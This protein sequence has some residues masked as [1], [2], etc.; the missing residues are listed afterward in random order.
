MG[1]PTYYN[2]GKKVCK[3]MTVHDIERYIARGRR[4]HLVGIG[5]VSM[6]PL[7]EVLHGMGMAITGSD[8]RESGTVEH[9]RAL[10]IPVA[11]GHRRE[12]VEGAELVIRTAA[13]HDAN[14]EI[15]AAREAGIPVFERAQ[16]WG[17]IMRSYK[18]ALCIAGTHGKTTTTSMCTH[19]IMAAGLDPTVMI[20]GT[21]PL[22]GAGH[23]VGKGDTIILESCEYCNSFLSFS[24]TVA[25][26]LNIEADHLDFFKDLEDVERSFRAF[27]DLVPPD[28]R[29][30]ANGEDENTMRTLA[31][32]ERP[33]TT[34]G[35]ER[36]DIH[37]AALQ[38]EKG[39]PT[40][41]V[42]VRGE[43]YAHVALG[44]PGL[45]NVKNALA[46][47]AA[48]HALGV[49]GEA[50]ERGLAQFR[51]AGRRFEHKG[52][53]HGAEIYDDYAH[54][55]GELQALLTT[56]KGLGYRRVIC[57]FQPH[58]YSR[59]AALFDDFVRVL[60]EPDV[61]ILAEIFAARETNDIGISSRDL[62]ER[63]PGSR[64]CA[65]LNEVEEVLRDL[66]RP[67]DL[68]LTVGAGDIYTVGE[69]LVSEA[70]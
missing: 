25:V 35:L 30:I 20:G 46:A 36:G 65:D 49:P 57:A 13:V 43:K 51:G 23:R 52:S 50:V 39:L 62:A 15:A 56:A 58:T 70:R 1:G 37:A 40:F 5:G 9:L 10:G 59:T 38:W 47:A 26:I 22:L 8:M 60:R 6:A 53:F 55:P 34:F 66:A 33:V 41:D 27:A 29:I 17:A 28:G 64:Y 11:I 63:I 44:V 32:E 61:T 19:I 48:A 16:A 2:M 24:P 12:N 3:P 21:L 68:I 31:G 69:A 42:V 45:H 7:A 14:P 18:N 54:H 67:G 4:A